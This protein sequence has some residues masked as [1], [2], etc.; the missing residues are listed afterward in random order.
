MTFVPIGAFSSTK[1]SIFDAVM[2]GGLLSTGL[3]VIV[4]LA[5]A[6]RFVSDTSTAFEKKKEN[7][8]LLCSIIL[9]NFGKKFKSHAL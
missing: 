4:N 9:P 1:P 3:T 8:Q 6:D 7:A 2:T 5:V